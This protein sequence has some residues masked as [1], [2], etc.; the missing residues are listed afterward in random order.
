MELLGTKLKLNKTTSGHFSVKIHQ[1]RFSERGER[2]ILTLAATEDL[3][4]NKVKK[5]HHYWGHCSVE[6]LSTVIE[7]A[8]KMTED[9]KKHLQKVKENCESCKVIR[10]RTPVTKV[11]IPRATRRN[12]IV[13]VDLKE[14]KDGRYILYV[15][16]MFTRFTVGVFIINKKAETVT[17][18]LL[19]KWISV[20]GTM[21]TLHKD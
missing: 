9:V 13:T 7:N 16:D 19:N 5:L 18:A 21:E 17:E 15:I 2:D 8:G 6:K 11:S 14:W 1:S 4:E 3:D 10:N 20:F 12:Q